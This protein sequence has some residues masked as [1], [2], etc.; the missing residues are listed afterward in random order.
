MT[1]QYRGG[2]RFVYHLHRRAWLHVAAANA[3]DVVWNMN[4]AVR[5]VSYQ[6]GSAP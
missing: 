4:D 6:V 5:V 3:P 2:R 1:V